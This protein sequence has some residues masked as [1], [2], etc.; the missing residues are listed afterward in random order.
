M[1]TPNDSALKL[2]YRQP[3]KGSPPARVPPKALLKL[4]LVASGTIAVGLLILHTSMHHYYGP[5][6]R[7]RV[8]CTDA[9][10]GAPVDVSSP[11]DYEIVKNGGVLADDDP[12]V[13]WSIGPEKGGTFT[14]DR[15]VS[16]DLE[17]KAPGYKKIQITL[18][19]NAPKKLSLKLSKEHTP[20]Q[21]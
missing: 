4:A 10:T 11:Y 1:G 7:T 20:G 3:P 2:D 8:F 17:I 19:S 16:I 18:D 14:V 13:K 5:I 15:N 12:D 9:A 6:L 21:P